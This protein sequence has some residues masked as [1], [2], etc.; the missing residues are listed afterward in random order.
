MPPIARFHSWNMRRMNP[1]YKYAFYD[2]MAIVHFLKEE[3]EP[4]VFE[5]YDKLTI[6]A[7]KADFFRY[8][9]LLKKGGIYVDIDSRVT[10]NLNK[11]IKAEDVAVISKEKNPG[12]YVQWALVFEKEHPFLQRTINKV[13][14]NIR[15]R[16]FPNSV[17]KTTGP[18]VYSEAIRECIK[19]KVGTNYR[20]FGIDYEGKIN[21]KY[22]LSRF[23]F[24]KKD[25]WKD[26]QKIKSVV[27][28]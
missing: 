25:H 8:A 6:G 18:S 2:D 22:Y 1:E 15:N 26:V 4:D 20:E 17:H 11:W 13:L 5:Q 19:E 28:Q 3:F 7:A 9:I 23:T 12:L 27:K 21:A 10:G 14:D 16:R 24:R